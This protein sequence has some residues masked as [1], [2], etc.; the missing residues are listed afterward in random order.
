[1]VFADFGLN[2]VIFAFK[3]YLKPAKNGGFNFCFNRD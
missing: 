1:M 3:Q 2:G